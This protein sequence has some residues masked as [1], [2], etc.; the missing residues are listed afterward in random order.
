MAIAI[1]NI[2]DNI[3]SNQND[4]RIQLLRQWDTIV[5]NLKTRVRLE[6][7]YNDTLV[8]GVYESHWMQE[9]FLLSKVLID[10]INRHLDEPRITNLRFKIVETKIGYKQL[11]QKTNINDSEII[12]NPNP[13][14]SEA[15]KKINDNQLAIALTLFLERCNKNNTLF[16][17][18]VR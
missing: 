4:W 6:K 1:K 5:G 13:Q 18:L 9:L 3:F 17:S 16:S 10:S 2:L 8:I 15:L 7:I 12:F 11:I 14:Q